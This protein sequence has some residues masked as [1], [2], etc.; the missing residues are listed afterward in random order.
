MSSFFEEIHVPTKGLVN[1]PEGHQGHNYC[2]DADRERS[3]NHTGVP[4][5]KNFAKEGKCESKGYHRT[6]YEVRHCGRNSRSEIR[7]KLFGSYCHK[8]CPIPD[9]NAQQE[10]CN[11]EIG[12][13]PARSKEEQQDRGKR[14]ENIDQHH[15]LSRANS[16]ADQAA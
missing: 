16:L 9:A 8:Q 14:K 6:A 7:A 10:T 13:G 3:V 15:L 11:I 5:T 12:C 1:G 4:A 2:E